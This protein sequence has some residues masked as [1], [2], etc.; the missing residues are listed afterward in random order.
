MIGGDP[1]LGSMKSTITQRRA[2]ITSQMVGL[3]PNNPNYKS[4]QD[5]LADLDKTL[6]R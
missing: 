6:I 4:Y 2:Q 5:E 3:T 1:G